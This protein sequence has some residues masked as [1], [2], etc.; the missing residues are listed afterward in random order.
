LTGNDY[1]HR[2]KDDSYSDRIIVYTEIFEH[3]HLFFSTALKSKAHVAR[4]LGVEPMTLMA[5]LAD[6]QAAQ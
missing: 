1:C 6:I 3:F 4:S 2:Q 5:T